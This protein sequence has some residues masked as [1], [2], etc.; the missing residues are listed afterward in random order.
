MYIYSLILIQPH[1]GNAI[2]SSMSA[3]GKLRPREMKPLAQGYT[4]S[5]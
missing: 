3:A 5:W 4:V 2:I 1:K